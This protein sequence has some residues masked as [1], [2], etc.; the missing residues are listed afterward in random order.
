MLHIL[1]LYQF[2]DVYLNG[3]AGVKSI[4]DDDYESYGFY[5]QIIENFQVVK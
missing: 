2:N 5:V 4:I 3:I 1:E